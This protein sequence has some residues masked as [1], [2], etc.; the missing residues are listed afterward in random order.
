[1]II[2]N[3][4]GNWD[5]TFAPLLHAQW[6][7][8]TPT[9]LVFP[10]FLFAVG[11]AMSFVLPKWEKFGNTTVLYKVLKRTFFIF[12]L[13]YLL[14]WF[15]FFH[16]QNGSWALN[17]IAE[18]RILG[19]L[20]RI[21]LCYGLAA[22]LIHFL[23]PNWV[24][25]ITVLILI[26]YRWVLQAFGDFSLEGNAVLHLDKWLFGESHLYHG[27]GIPFDPEGLL[28]TFPAI[29]NVVFGFFA[30]R[31]LQQKEKN[32]TP[33][34]STYEGLTHLLLAGS[35]LLLLAYGWNSSFPINK[36]LWTS[37]FVLLTTG[38]DLIILAG[39][40]YVLEFRE[41]RKWAHFFEV[42]GK[43]PLFIYLLSELGVIILYLIPVGGKSLYNWL[44]LNVFAWAGAYTGAFLFAVWWMLTCWLA[45]WW[46]DRKKIY[47][48]V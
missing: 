1:M 35:L 31:Y 25:G 46:L 9:D 5:T 37:S 47:L 11:N 7:G 8:F 38:L 26:G 41:K 17:P 27:E 16:Q 34:G 10:S 44:Y 24:L 6:H 39:I 43:N 20:Q 23:K 45:G 29:G 33:R 12:L 42:F 30:G 15:P 3:S 36:K 14:Y 48:R 18:T 32:N 21:A 22:L 4:S 28:S 40:I 13:G 2:V 19:V